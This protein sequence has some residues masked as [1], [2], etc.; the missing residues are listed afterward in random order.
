MSTVAHFIL[1]KAHLFFKLHIC[2]AFMDATLLLHDAIAPF[3]CN[4]FWQTSHK[5][6][7]NF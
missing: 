2:L 3:A 1:P 7:T 4:V 5:P 6:V